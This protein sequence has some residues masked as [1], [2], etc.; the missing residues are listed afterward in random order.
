MKIFLTGATGFLGSHLI[1]S[2]AQD[3]ETVYILSRKT[4][5]PFLD[6]FPNVKLIK[7][8][9]THLDIIES[10]SDWQELIDEVDFVLH[11]AA[12][13]D[14]TA[15]FADCYLQNVVG[16]QNL[17]K[18]VKKIK[19]I[20]AFY[21]VSTIAVGDEQSYFL[22]EDHLPTR[23]KFIDH[24]SETKYHA[25]MIVREIGQQ[26]PIRIFRPGII[27]GDSQTGKMDKVDGP[28]Y[29]IRAI[30]KYSHLL[31]RIPFLPMSFN[32]RTK[33]PLI[34]VDHCARFIHLLIKRDNLDSATKTYHLISH[35]TPTTSEFLKDMHKA[36]GI[37]THYIPVI[38]NSIHKTILNLLG[39]PRELVPFMFSKLSYDKSRTKSELPEIEES[40]YFNYK[41]QLFK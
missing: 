33:I 37:K 22:E 41:D 4:N 18:L 14:L 20:K 39:I 5:H 21:Y 13:Y 36:Y 23:K 17:L 2:L 26:I 15:S 11:A 6:Q 7:G 9:I 34:P 16:T 27:V 10:K 3:Y 25:E 1:K 35:E 28:Y 32:P 8:D 31:K 30:K 12:L 19:N 38:E 29:F 40:S 24:Y